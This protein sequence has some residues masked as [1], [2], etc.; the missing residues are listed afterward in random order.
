MHPSQRSDEG[1]ESQSE[2]TFIDY[3][4]Q[5]VEELIEAAQFYE[6]RQNGLGIRFLNA[7]E[8]AVASFQ[9]DP[10]IWKPDRLGRRKY[11]IWKF[12]YLLI[13]KVIE[14]RVYILAVAHTSRKPGYWKSR[15]T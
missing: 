12:P 2:Q 3:H 5:A 9:I 4:P 14:S 6:S 1:S 13:Y 15:D 11:R 8:D 7:V 10:L